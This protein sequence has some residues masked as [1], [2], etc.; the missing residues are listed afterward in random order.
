ME[1]PYLDDNVTLNCCICFFLVLSETRSTFLVLRYCNYTWLNVSFFTWC[2]GVGGHCLMVTAVVCLPP[3]VLTFADFD[4]YISCFSSTRAV[5]SCWHGTQG[6][7][8]SHTHSG[9]YTHISRRQTTNSLVCLSHTL[10]PYTR[11]RA[12]V[13]PMQYR[14]AVELPLVVS[15]CVVNDVISAISGTDRTLQEHELFY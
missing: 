12:V 2:P 7:H 14:N 3:V 11:Y 6:K 8:T 1:R 13:I 15:A 4:M 9:I 5:S 10:L